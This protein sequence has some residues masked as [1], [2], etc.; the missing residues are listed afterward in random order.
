MEIKIVLMN[1]I[2]EN[3]LKNIQKLIQ[4]EGLVFLNGEYC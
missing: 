3:F 1:Q 2:E 4:T